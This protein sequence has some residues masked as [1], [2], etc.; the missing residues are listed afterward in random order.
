[1]DRP[2]WKKMTVGE[3]CDTISDTYCRNDNEVVLINTSDV[4][5]GKVLN[6]N[7]VENKQL[8]GQFKKTFKKDDILYSEI[9]PANKRYAFVDFEDTKQYI[10][11]TKLMVLRA[12]KELVLPRFLFSFLTSNKV[13][14]ELQLLAETRSGTFPQITFSSELATMTIFV[15]DFSTQEKIV[16]IIENIDAKI[17]NNSRINDNLLQ[18]AQ[19][20]FK[21]WFTD[22]P[23]LDDMKQ[24]PL[25][26]L[27][28]VVTKGTTPTTLGKPF[29]TEGIN[30]IKVES[31]LDNHTFDQNKFA[32]IDSETNNLLKRSI[33]NSG[34]IIFTI[35][36]TLGRFAL[37][38]DSV[39]PANTNQAVA[40]IRANQNK[41]TPDYLYS[42]FLGNWH[43]DYYRKRIQQA[44]QANLNL[45]TIKSLPIPILPD[46]AM[47]EY[48]G[49]L[50]P[51]ITMT[52]ANELEITRLRAIRD[53]LLPKL[54]SGQVDVS[55]I[56][57]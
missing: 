41:V 36:G 19:A 30:F 35:A 29:V 49:I 32:F 55:A 24:V 18:Q 21:H 31:I 39:L 3:L 33:I 11:S 48:L 2:N 46:K 52:K 4:L 38:D 53:T 42:F 51:I 56:E 9:R 1:M 17:Q 25:A 57:L 14:A 8:K 44:V 26:E 47:S 43:N 15:P 45:G 50:S 5:E 40:I 34:D 6:H 54:M 27:C 13:L 12:N 10:A 7:R 37:I 23:N 16:G 22:N 28:L 20:I